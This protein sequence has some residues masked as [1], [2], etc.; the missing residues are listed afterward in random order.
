M[1]SPTRINKP[2]S[3]SKIVVEKIK[4]SILNGS[5]KP[6]TKLI[7]TQLTNSLG[8]SR[9]P[10]R[11]AFRELAVEGYIIIYPHKGAFVT[12]ITKEEIKDLYMITSVLEGLATRLATPLLTL[13]KNRKHLEKLLEELRIFEQSSEVSK[14]WET[15]QLFHQ[16]ITNSCKNEK[17]KIVIN[18]LRR[19]ILKTRII[20]LQVPGR[21]TSSMEEHEKILEFILKNEGGKAE[22]MVIKH[23]E[24]QGKILYDLT[25]KPE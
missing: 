15:N 17:L 10:L 3:L 4:D 21:L 12:K 25:D 11:E 1:F 5:L 22:K 6:G 2:K 8:V 24:L 16:F 14:Y 7:E 13:G 20:T 19:Q 9:T 23:L 18:N